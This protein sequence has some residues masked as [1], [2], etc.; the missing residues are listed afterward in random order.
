MSAAAANVEVTEEKPSVSGTSDKV[1][2][3]TKTALSLTLAYLIPMAL[4]WAQPQTAAITVML[5][6]ATGSL[7]ESLQKGVLRTLGTIAGAVIGLSLIALFPQDRLLYLCAISIFVLITLYLYNAY[8]GDSTI[9]MLTMVVGLMVFNGGDA[10]GAFIYGIDRTLLTTFGVLVYSLVGSFLWPV[11]VADNTERLASAVSA[12]FGQ[13][14]KLL[15]G[16]AEPE[17]R[18]EQETEALENLLERLTEFRSH[19]VTVKGNADS[20]QAYQ[21]EWDTILSCFGKLES[22][23][24]PA[25][26]GGDAATVGFDQY[27]DNYP[28]VLANLTDLL[29]AVQASWQGDAA[30]TPSN[31]L[32]SR[33]DHAALQQQDHL[34]IAAVVC[35]GELLN[36]L[37][38]LLWQLHG[39]II[40]LR[41]DRGSFQR[42]TET[43]STASFIWFDRENLKTALRGFFTFWLATFIWIQFNPP[44]GFM[45]VTLCTALIPLV[46]YTPV[47]PKLLI[48]LFTF[49]FVFA[50]PAYVFLLPGMTHWLEL[51]VFLFGYA[52]LGF[53]LFPGPVAIFFLLGL[54]TLGIQNTMQY[55]FNVILLI[56]LMF[57]M[58][59]ALLII[60]VHFPFTS[61]P[62]LLYLNFRTRFF[63]LCT[64]IIRS[65]PPRTYW[66]R[67]VSQL[68]ITAATSLLAKMNQW[69]AAIDNS[70]FPDNPAEKV[71]DFNHS[72]EILLA[73]LRV[74]AGPNSHYVDNPLIKRATEGTASRPA[75][76][77]CATL[78]TN[79]DGVIIE[80]AFAKVRADLLSIEDQLNDYLGA[81][82]EEKSSDHYDSR[83]TAVFYVYI[84]LQAS[85]LKSID[86]CRVSLLALNWRQLRETKF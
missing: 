16:G 24:I 35:Q 71:V 20:I 42:E 79:D 48:F 13:V 46:S 50:V 77:L 22:S 58:V 21:A 38:Q 33:Y 40:S 56:I 27:I 6:A 43:Y 49:G 36:E 70:Y 8:Q 73:R 12:E 84:N 3:A 9:F 1:K 81:H 66:E 2:F 18:Q 78:A 76:T 72:C 60:S 86:H 59:C 32:A 80:Q 47:S 26:R 45:F 75:A 57:Y 28:A 30:G 63:Q 31:P 54:F 62:Q 85:I 83:E 11:K 7:S 53:L 19:Y 29:D 25:L 51:A 5:I 4:G 17:N 34:T 65:G 44:G 10:E 39:A 82:S 61:K 74:L 41:F 37:Q 69:G 68:R 23:L 15:I 14:G 55:N 64:K 67:T 52:F